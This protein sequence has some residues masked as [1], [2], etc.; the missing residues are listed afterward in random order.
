MSRLVFLLEEPSMKVFLGALLPR[1][2][3]GVPFLCIAHNGKKDLE[4]SI[5]KKLKAWNAPGDQFIV[6]RDN[7]GGDCVA[8]KERLLALCGSAGSREVL[9]RIACQE[10]EAWFLGAPA[11]LAQVYAQPSLAAL[12]RKNPYR[13]PDTIG[14]SSRLLA[15]HVR[16]YGKTDGARRMGSAMGRENSSPSFQALLRGVERMASRLSRDSG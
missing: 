11:T 10:L 7:D 15:Q 8:L 9:V 12:A 16:K 2:F 3:P 5:P 14:S 4:A 13:D 6:I 1:L